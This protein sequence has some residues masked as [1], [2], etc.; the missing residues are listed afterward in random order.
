MDNAEAV[1]ID[2]GAEGH[3]GSE[4]IAGAV[5]GLGAAERRRRELADED[6]AAIIRDELRQHLDAAARA[7]AAGKPELA[8]EHAG[9]AGVLLGYV[10]EP[11]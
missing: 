5:S 8:D 3:L 7:T 11:S 1:E 4:H 6:V 9:Q 10:P 2:T